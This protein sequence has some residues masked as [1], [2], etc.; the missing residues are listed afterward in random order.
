[1]QGRSVLFKTTG[2]LTTEH[3]LETPAIHFIRT[4][5][6]YESEQPIRTNGVPRGHPD[7][8]LPMCDPAVLS[9]DKS[10]CK[11]LMQG[12]HA[13]V[14]SPPLGGQMQEIQHQEEYSR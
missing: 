14:I 8:S 7:V 5:S 12:G 11:E 9:G 3:Y 10:S 6:R 4:P 1:M 2:P 13:S